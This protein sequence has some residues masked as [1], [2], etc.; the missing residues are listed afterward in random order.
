MD[1]INQTDP[2]AFCHTKHCANTGI[3]LIVKMLDGKE[4]EFCFAHAPQVFE[5]LKRCDISTLTTLVDIIHIENKLINFVTVAKKH[6]TKKNV[7]PVVA[8]DVEID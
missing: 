1:T 6:T 3:S 5:A 4:L 7:Q 8:N 2:I